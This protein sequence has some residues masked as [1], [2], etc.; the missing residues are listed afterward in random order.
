[1]AFLSTE[2]GLPGGVKQVRTACLWVGHDQKG[3][4]MVRRAVN[5]LFAIL[6]RLEILLGASCAD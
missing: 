3:V 2:Q 5:D 4:E 1:M 6:R